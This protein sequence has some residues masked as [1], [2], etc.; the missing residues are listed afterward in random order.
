[1]YWGF[2]FRRCVGQHL[3]YLCFL[4]SHTCPHLTDRGSGMYV[5]SGAVFLA[6][7]LIIAP[8]P[9]ALLSEVVAF[10]RHIFLGNHSG[11]R[12]LFHFRSKVL[13]SPS[14]RWACLAL[15]FCSLIFGSPCLYS[16]LNTTL[17]WFLY[18]HH[19][20]I[21]RWRIFHWGPDI[22]RLPV[23]G[24]LGNTSSNWWLGVVS[25]TI[26]F[27]SLPQI[28]IALGPFTFPIFPEISR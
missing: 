26:H 20:F 27:S 24:A 13:P 15:E 2:I 23:G 19:C 12:F 11:S 14:W 4:Y 22:I 6:P 7:I 10:V 25:T 5:V 21:Q 18:T 17:Y 8:R 3:R 28:P 9:L 16:A 1:M